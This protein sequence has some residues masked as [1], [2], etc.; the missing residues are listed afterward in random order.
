MDYSPKCHVE[1]NTVLMFSYLRVA[2]F[3]SLQKA[4]FYF[5]LEGL[6]KAVG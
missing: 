1:M 3:L 6:G 5:F 4:N 2:Y